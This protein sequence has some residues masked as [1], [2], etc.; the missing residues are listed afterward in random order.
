M[1]NT[2]GGGLFLYQVLCEQREATKHLEVIILDKK[3]PLHKSVRGA[4]S[5]N[6]RRRNG[7][8]DDNYVDNDCLVDG[9]SRH[10]TASTNRYNPPPPKCRW[11]MRSLLSD[12]LRNR[13]MIMATR[14]G[15]IS[16]SKEAGADREGGGDPDGKLERLSLC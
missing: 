4:F 5:E 3:L 14:L 7:R 11:E 16:H 13:H 12:T 1:N 8:R 10:R 6:S 2:S 9:K 15:S